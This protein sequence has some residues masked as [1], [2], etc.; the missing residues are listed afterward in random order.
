MNIWYE[1]AACFPS[2][3]SPRSLCPAGHE[4]DGA[5]GETGPS[6]LP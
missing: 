1:H 3:L 2:S 6:G 5:S 4:A